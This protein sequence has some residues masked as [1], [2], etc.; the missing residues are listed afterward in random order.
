MSSPAFGT[1]EW[2]AAKDFAVLMLL[3]GGNRYAARELWLRKVRIHIEAPPGAGASA[4]KAAQ[5]VAGRRP[6]PA[7][8]RAQA[9]PKPRTAAQLASRERGQKR[10]NQKHLARKMWAGVRVASRLLA[11][12]IRARAR[13]VRDACISHVRSLALDGFVERSASLGLRAALSVPPGCDPVG[14]MGV[15][16]PLCCRPILIGRLLVQQWP[17]TW[18][19]A[20]IARLAEARRQRP[21]RPLQPPVPALLAPPTSSSAAARP[22]PALTLAAPPPP[23]LTLAAPPPATQLAALAPPSQPPPSALAAAARASLDEFEMQDD[24][25]EKRDAHARTPPPAA[26]PER[27]PPAESRKKTRGSGAVQAAL[28]A[29]APAAAAPQPLTATSYH[30][31]SLVAANPYHPLA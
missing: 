25:G 7:P 20:G 27:P 21:W 15:P 6:K 9:V 4:P 28:A 22:P 3:T 8:A 26:A 12:L 13:H 1:P 16:A 10:L 24:R 2:S 23:A 17:A 18:D 30:P 29:A 14:C 19:D 31:A 5:Q 11:W